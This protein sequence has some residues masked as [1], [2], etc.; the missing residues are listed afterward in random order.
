MVGYSRNFLLA[1]LVLFLASSALA[2]AQDET[3]TYQLSGIIVNSIT[4]KPIPRVL[5][6]I[7]PLN[8]AMVTGPEGDFSFDGLREGKA[9]IQL[10]KPGYF[11]PGQHGANSLPYTVHIGKETGKVVLKLAPTA[12]IGGTILGNGEEPL[13]GVQVELLMWR[14]LNG[15]RQLVSEGANTVSDE[16]GNYRISGLAP[17]R[18]YLQI[19]ASGASRTILGAQAANGG[20]SYPAGIYFPAG[21]DVAG[22]EPLDL[23]AGQYKEA[24][25]SLKT[26]PTFRIA[27][28]ISNPG[29]WKLLPPMFVNDVQQP[30]ILPIR[31]EA[32]SGA[33][34]FRSV[35]EGRYRLQLG[36]S[37]ATGQYISRFE[38]LA[39]HSN[40]PDLQLVIRPGLDIPVVVHE[41]F[42]KGGQRGRCWSRDAAGEEHQ[43]DCSELPAVQVEMYSLDYAQLEF[44]SNDGPPQGRSLGLNPGISSNDGFRVRGVAPGRYS[45]HA[46]PTFGGYVQSLRCNGVDLLREP[47]M[48]SEG[49]EVDPIEVVLRDDGAMLQTKI[50]AAGAE[51]QV[52]V[53][54]FPDPMT[55]EPQ[56]TARGFGNQIGLGPIPPG[57]YKVFA[58][59]SNEEFEISAEKMTKYAAQAAS[60]TVG[61]NENASVVLELIHIGE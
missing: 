19:N 31:F 34:E 38:T 20:E 57:T 16:D 36:G 41:D 21:N 7:D 52:Q 43:S 11:R 50:P 23:A 13:E 1:P 10:T 55:T 30:V 61:A 60:V 59:D 40:L 28:K 49:D 51:Q 24:N 26:V 53:V 29:D 46:T 18:Y 4:G 3:R 27:G 17:G 54:V 48:V 44:R 39:V 25:F 32:Q 42:V 12:V 9:Q 14:V 35:P 15:R 47:L 2:Q 58:F 22:A 37:D 8:A 33:F 5:V 45:V 56:T 6:H